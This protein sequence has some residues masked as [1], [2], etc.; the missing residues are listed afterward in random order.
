MVS[1][2]IT[3]VR[4]AG[5]VSDLAPRKGAG[6]SGFAEHAQGFRRVVAVVWHSGRIG[7]CHQRQLSAAFTG[8]HRRVLEK[9]VTVPACACGWE[10]KCDTCSTHSPD[11]LELPGSNCS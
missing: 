9:L 1:I 11:P 2:P 10:R 8:L 5:S 7:S 3:S 4:G 6:K